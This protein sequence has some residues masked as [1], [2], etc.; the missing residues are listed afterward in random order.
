MNPESCRDCSV[1]AASGEGQGQF[2]PLIRREYQAGELLYE[3]GGEA[4]YVW[5]V[6][7]G[8]LEVASEPQVSQDP[9]TRDRKSAGSFVGLESLIRDRYD[10]T[11]RAISDSTLCGA[12][13]AGFAQWL[14]PQSQRT[15][16]ILRD[17]LG[18][19]EPSDNTQENKS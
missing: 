15:C 10:G 14:G 3:Q 4:N 11:A 16:T 5:Y 12:S 7:S 9:P 18:S 2:C 8:A 17:L 1:G 13:R 19:Q 6:R